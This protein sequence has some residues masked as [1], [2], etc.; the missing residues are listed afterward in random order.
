MIIS[1]AFS[2]LS[3]YF[4]DLMFIHIC[5]FLFQAFPC[6]LHTHLKFY[7]QSCAHLPSSFKFL[8][9]SFLLA[10]LVVFILRHIFIPSLCFSITIE[11]LVLSI[12]V[13][14]VL[15]IY[16]PLA[17]FFLCCLFVCISILHFFLFFLIFV[18]GYF[19]RSFVNLFACDVL[20]RWG[21]WK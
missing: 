7:V 3:Q 16:L 18:V 4:V 13:H 10:L 11:S 15:S 19:C 5:T 14:I 8:Y 1:F 9:K 20:L 17:W 2:R 6:L 12:N 21:H